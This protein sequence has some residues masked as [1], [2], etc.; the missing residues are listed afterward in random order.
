MAYVVPKL[1]DLSQRA[2]RLFAEAIPGAIVDIWPNTFAVVAKVMAALGYEIHLRIRWLVRQLFASTADE[3]WLVRHGYEL[4]LT[5]IPA[6]KAAGFA[7]LAVASGTTVPA[8]VTVRRGD[9]ALF[10]TRTSAVGAGPATSLEFEALTA[11]AAGNTLAGETLELI[12][13][14]YAGTVGATATVAAGGIGGGADIEDIEA[15]RQRILDRKRRPPQGGSRSDWERWAKETDGAVTRVFVDAFANDIRTVWLSF[16]RRDRA[17][18]VPTAADVAAVQAYVGDD[19]RRPVTARVTVVAPV[20]Q[21]VAVTIAGL[22]PDT[23]AVRAAIAAELAAL[24][25]ERTA[26]ATPNVPFVL[27]RSW[28]TEAVARAT[29]ED[30]HRVTVPADD[31]TYTTPGHMPVLGTITYV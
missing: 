31:L 10:A 5:R 22:A 20:P 18:G 6:R 27:S 7:T 28:I 21:A 3:V 14:A 8:G 13:L 17:N 25:A 1:A 9:G 12:D 23:T 19:M 11:G 4:G 24:F 16:L 2:R 15:F 26:P 29:G 30:R